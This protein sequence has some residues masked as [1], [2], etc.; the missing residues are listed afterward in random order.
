MET[1]V[2]LN[3]DKLSQLIIITQYV[4]TVKG[5]GVSKIKFN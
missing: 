1:L 4:E 3:Y 5:I 2:N